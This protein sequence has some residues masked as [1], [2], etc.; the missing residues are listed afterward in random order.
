MKA[1]AK[2]RKKLLAEWI[3]GIVGDV[4][5]TPLANDASARSYYRV[6]GGER[7]IIAMDA[8]APESV[9]DFVDLAALFSASGVRVPALHAFDEE[10]GFCLLEDLGDDLLCRGHPPDGRHYAQAWRTLIHIQQNVDPARLP[11]F[12]RAFIM[13]ELELF[14]QWYCAEFKGRPLDPA[15]QD[16]YRQASGHLVEAL[17][18][19]PQVA[20]H[21][22]YHSRNLM[23]VADE[24]AVIDFQGAMRGPIAYDPASLGKDLYAPMAAG[25]E[26]EALARFHA[27]AARAGLPVAADFS[28]YLLLYEHAAAQRLTKILGLFV[29]VSRRLGKDRF[30]GLPARLCAK[31]ACHRIRTSAA[32]ADRA[33][34]RSQDMSA[35]VAMV[36]AAG[37]GRRLLPLT[38][39][40]PKPLIEVA[41]RPLIEHALLRLRTAGISRCVINVS[42]L[43]HLIEKRLGDG[44]RFGLQISY[45]REERPL[46]AG[47]GIATALPLLGEKPFVVLNSDVISGYRIESLLPLAADFGNRLGHLVL[48]ANPQHNQD[49]DFSIA[50]GRARP[51]AA[52]EALTYTGCA[53]FAPRLFAA[54]PPGR[55]AALR[56]LL[57]QAIKADALSAEHYAESW[58]DAGDPER[59][60]DAARL[61][62]ELSGP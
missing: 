59:L 61:A 45:S 18:G 44:S 15:E 19:Q 38:E 26:A 13:R 43:G 11:P 56:P 4:T 20:M 35:V 23:V 40:L 54:L 3:K 58:I 27:E 2:Q 24:I 57:L 33:N 53:L 55:I 51:A 22:D 32:A 34:H 12:D 16:G 49:G 39:T 10:K 21:R 14:P 5:I 47:G 50:A 46:E 37:R 41:G 31:A 25:A 9:R 30:P 17:V 28:D 1:D 62:E 6:T 42:H 60:K 8:P 52:G 7:A 29:R 48:G 36:L